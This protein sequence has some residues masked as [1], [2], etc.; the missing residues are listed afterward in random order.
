M[1]HIKNCMTRPNSL[2]AGYAP[3]PAPTAHLSIK[4]MKVK[5][6]NVIF[7]PSYILGLTNNKMPYR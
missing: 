3:G 2:A 1:M 6:E 5:P 7:V 4:S